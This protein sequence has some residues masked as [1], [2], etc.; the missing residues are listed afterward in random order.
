MNDFRRE[1]P[2]E[3]QGSSI[4]GEASDWIARSDRGLSADE[5]D[6]LSAW[7]SADVRHERELARLTS[8][9]RGLDAVGELPEIRMAA[10]AMDA[11][12]VRRK[13]M[14][15]RSTWAVGAAA[16]MALAW[17]MLSEKGVKSSLAQIEHNTYQIVP[18]V[19]ERMTLPDGTVIELKGNS[20]VQPAFSGEERR[21]RLLSGEAF[22]QVAKDPTRPFVVQVE[23]INVR[24]VGTAFNMRVASDE[25]EVLV[26]EGKVQLNNSRNNQSLLA[27]APTANSGEPSDPPLLI[28]GHRVVVATN[29]AHPVVPIAATPE[30]LHRAQEWQG[31]RLRFQR[32]PLA[33]VVAAFNRLNRCQLVLGEEDL[34]KRWVSGTFR[35]DSVDAFVR[36]L[37]AGFEIGAEHRSENEIVLHAAR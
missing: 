29:A 18:S 22:F 36:L 13:R 5:A 25:V 10:R 30:D 21:V 12:R 35:A 4:E 27:R 2:E 20:I 37:E 32:T 9:W 7:R 1:N 6:R 11:G 24:A 33:Q 28:A 16:S 8:A 17:T 34:G 19:A 26:T 31:T 3:I 15:R 23:S 14:I